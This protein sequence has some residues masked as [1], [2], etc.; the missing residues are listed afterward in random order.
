MVWNL[1]DTICK[2]HA[3]NSLIVHDESSLVSL[4]I[5]IWEKPAILS[6][7]SVM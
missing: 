4:L 5:M 3:A 1:Y 7:T 2:I 6:C